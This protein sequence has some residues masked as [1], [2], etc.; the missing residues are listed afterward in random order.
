MSP[1]G[2]RHD[3]ACQIAPPGAAVPTFAYLVATLP[4]LPPPPDLPAGC[5]VFATTLTPLRRRWCRQC[6]AARPSRPLPSRRSCNDLHHLQLTLLMYLRARH[7]RFGVHSQP[8]VLAWP[9]LCQGVFIK[10]NGE[11]P[12]SSR[13]EP[14]EREPKHMPR[15]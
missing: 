5:Q 2:L 14:V 11:R 1:T 7:H 6:S 8:T 4:T 10:N 13:G 3:C 9:T 12:A 15:V